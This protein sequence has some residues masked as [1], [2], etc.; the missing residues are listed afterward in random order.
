VVDFALVGGLLSLIF[1][2]VLQLGIAMYAHNMLVSCAAEGA[3]Y[4]ARADR[5]P[6]DA[7]PRTELLITET[8]NASYADDVT[9]AEEIVDGVR[10]VVVRVRAPLPLFGFFG[11]SR[12]MSATGHAF[13]EGQ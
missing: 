10:T 6:A 5:E 1:A 8:L 4:A 12:A 2:A 3:R 13:M 7:R 9:S 11:P